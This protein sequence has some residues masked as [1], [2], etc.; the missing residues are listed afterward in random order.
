M[1]LHIMVQTHGAHTHNTHKA[2]ALPSHHHP[3]PRMNYSHVADVL[4]RFHFAASSF[5]AAMSMWP[6]SLSISRPNQNHIFPFSHYY[7]NKSH[8]A[9]ASVLAK[10][11]LYGTPHQRCWNCYKYNRNS[12]DSRWPTRSTG[13]KRRTIGHC[14]RNWKDSN[15]INF[16]HWPHE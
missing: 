9:V 7:E 10:A 3:L 2:R 15:E 8:S 11:L 4:K 1:V 13:M 6:T 14:C 12:I 16:F 5:L